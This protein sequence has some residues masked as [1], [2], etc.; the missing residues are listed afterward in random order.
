MACVHPAC[1]HALAVT[2]RC[3]S[4]KDNL[5]SLF[6]PIVSGEDRPCL[7]SSFSSDIPRDIKTRNHSTR[8]PQRPAKSALGA[9]CGESFDKLSGTKPR[10]WRILASTTPEPVAP[11]RR[12]RSTSASLIRY[13]ERTSDFQQEPVLPIAPSL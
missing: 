3:L 5:R 6:N 12:E 7:Q 10:P 11:L 9:Y 4:T 2:S 1:L 13:P 8:V